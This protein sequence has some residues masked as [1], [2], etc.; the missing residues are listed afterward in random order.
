MASSMISCEIVGFIVRVSACQTS[1]AFGLAK[2]RLYAFQKAPRLAYGLLAQSSMLPGI[3]A[4][5]G[6][7]AAKIF[8]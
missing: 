3:E 6:R 7:I 4:I 1:V 2:W 5:A 8:V